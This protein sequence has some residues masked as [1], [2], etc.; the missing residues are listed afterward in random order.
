MHY[1]ITC[2]VHCFQYSK[3][4]VNVQF[5]LAFEH[6]IYDK[7]LCRNQYTTCHDKKET[8]IAIMVIHSFFS[9]RTWLKQKCYD[10]FV[11]L[12]KDTS[13]STL[14]FLLGFSGMRWATNN[15]ERAD[16]VVEKL[17]WGW[18]IKAFLLSPKSM[19]NATVDG[20]L[21]CIT[22]DVQS[23]VSCERIKNG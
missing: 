8:S 19:F 18:L 23:A 2:P 21:F 12:T 5:G 13:S 14:K 1:A 20:V 4:L 7:W 3:M 11:V 9:R 16:K 17:K 6:Y 10:L 22:T 15:V